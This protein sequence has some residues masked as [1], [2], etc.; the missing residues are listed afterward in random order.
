MTPVSRYAGL[1]AAA[2]GISAFPAFAQE[3]PPPAT[4][5]AAPPAT[6]P[7]PPPAA[8]P[9]VTPPPPA[10][11]RPATKSAP[12]QTNPRSNMAIGPMVKPAP[13]VK[14]PANVAARVGGRDI[15]R[16]EVLAMF[17]MQHGRPLITQMVQVIAVEQEAKRLGVFIT[18]AELNPAVKKAEQDIVNRMMQGGTPMTFAEFA[19]QNGI[20]EDMVRYSVGLDLLRRKTLTKSLE[21]QV[22][23]LD[24]QYKLAHILIAT[25]PLQ[26]TQEG[27][28]APVSPE[29][30][31]KKD[32]AA[33]AKADAI[34]ADIRAGRAT[35][36]DAAKLNSDDK[37]NGEK[38]GLLGWSSSGF[39]V[40]EFDKAAFAMQ[41]PGEIVG[42]IK[43]N[44]G[45]H[46]IKLIAKGSSAT[47]AEKAAYRKEQVDQNLNNPQVANQW[48]ASLMERAKVVVNPSVRLVPN[49][50]M[51]PTPMGS[52][53]PA[54][55]VKKT[56]K[57]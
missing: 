39:F 54:K 43:T 3:T 6:A 40:P 33:K 50:K 12:P 14:L 31:K 16:E 48:L 24:K 7:V 20:T 49:A 9:V 30:Q 10:P 18:P 56:A 17:D 22:L 35:F 32:D 27:V 45:W 4:P 44:F 38:G 25:I 15:T 53:A 11:K 21:S 42:P 1:L 13:P 47:P 52:S 57:K 19:T 29:E 51:P 37:S 28:Q 55:P 5:P 46:I 41:K 34:L 36:E 2:I 23:P 26:N 8:P